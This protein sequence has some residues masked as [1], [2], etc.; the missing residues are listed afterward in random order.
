VNKKSCEGDDLVDLTC[1]NE[2]MMIG[3][4]IVWI[5]KISWQH[6]FFAFHVLGLITSSFKYFLFNYMIAKIDSRNKVT[7]QNKKQKKYNG[8][9]KKFLLYSCIK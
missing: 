3:K 6:F 7:K 9:C 8:L 1:L 2:A 4:N 5:E